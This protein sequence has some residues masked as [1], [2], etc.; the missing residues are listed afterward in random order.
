MEKTSTA[1]ASA[2][3]FDW[4]SDDIVAV[5][6]QQAIAVYLNP[7]GEIVIRQQEWPDNDIWV[8]VHRCYARRLI[9]A[10]EHLLLPAKED[11]T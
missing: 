7:H 10:I 4:S 1:P 3:E 2:A 5:R 11:V 6:S 8:V 9:E